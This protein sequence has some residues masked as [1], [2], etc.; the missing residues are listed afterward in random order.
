MLGWE[1]FVMRESDGLD[2]ASWATGIGGID[3]LYEWVKTGFATEEQ[4]NGYPNVY[5]FKAAPLLALLRQGQ[6]PAFT[7]REVLSDE[8]VWPA[9]EVR[10]LRIHE[11]ALAQVMPDEVLK[12]EAWDQS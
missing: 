9:G 2:I 7:G 8:G 10:S 1:I 4:A 12:V 3:W 5:T 6:V 11:Q